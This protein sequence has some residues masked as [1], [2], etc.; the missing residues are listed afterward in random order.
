MALSLAA[1]LQSAR[2]VIGSK[3]DLINDPDTGDKGLT[4]DLVLAESIEAYLAATSDNPDEL[5]EGTL[6]STL[7]RAQM[8]AIREI[9]DE[10]QATFNR[11]GIGFKGFVPATFARLVNERFA[12]KVGTEASMKVTA[13]P[14]LVRNRKSRPDAWETEIIGN[15]LMSDNWEDGAIYH[16]VSQ[17]DGRAGYRVLVPEYYGEA[18]LACHGGPAGE[19]DMTGY[20]KEG[21]ALNDLGGV[22]SI[23]IF[24]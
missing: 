16:D 14:H 13:P 9:I 3:Q 23:T 4:G 6:K 19:I 12:E 7:L 5:T 20:P 11:S 21:G 2:K 15:H 22:I 1:M 10:N 18:C 8:D 24:Q 17:L